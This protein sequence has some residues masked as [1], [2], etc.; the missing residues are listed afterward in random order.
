[1]P[2]IT[3]TLSVKDQIQESG[4]DRGFAARSG[5][6]VGWYICVLLQILGAP[7]AAQTA[8]RTVNYSIRHFT[9]ENGLPQN[10]VKS[11]A[12]DQDGFIWLATEMGL[13]RFDGQS[14]LT[15]NKEQSGLHSNQIIS[16]TPDLEGRKGQLYAL[17]ALLDHIKIS[18]GKAVRDSNLLESRFPA[19][20]RVKDGT[21]G[22]AYS[23]GLPDPY[24]GKHPVTHY[25]F[26]FP[27]KKGSFYLWRKGGEIDLYENW[28]K[29]KTYRTG[30]L[31]PFGIFRLGRNLYIDDRRG[32]IELLAT[33]SRSLEKPGKIKLTP[34]RSNHALPDL[35]KP[36][37]IYSH[38]LTGQ[39]FIRQGLQLY[40]LSHDAAGNI[41]TDL[42]LQYFDFQQTHVISIFFD[43]SNRRLFMGTLNNGLFILDLHAF[44]TLTVDDQNPQSNIFYSHIAYSDSTVL[45]PSFQVLGKKAS[46]QTIAYALPQL[47]RGAS[48]NVNTVLISRTGDIWYRNINVLY[49]YDGQSKQLKGKWTIGKDGFQI[50]ED[51]TGRIWIGTY[52]NGLLYIDPREKGTPVHAF[53]P[54]IKDIIF[55]LEDGADIVWVATGAGLFKISHTRKTFSLVP[56]TGNFRVKSLFLFKAGELWLNTYAHGLFLLQGNRLTRLPLDKKKILSNSHCFL[57]DKN[58]FL[59]VTT[60]HGLFRFSRREALEFTDHRDSTRLYYHRFS[61]RNGFYIDEFNGTCEPCAVSLGNGYVSLPSIHGLVFF[62]PELTPLDLPD[63]QIFIDRIEVDSREIPVNGPKLELSDVSDMHV[64]VSSP[65]LGNREN[66]QLYYS[67]SSDRKANATPIWYP[68]ENDQQSIHLNNLE[69]GTYILKIRKNTGFGPKSEQLT[70]LTIVIPYAWYET[71]PFKLIVVTLVLVAIYFYFKTRLKK[72]DRMNRILES[73]VSEKTRNLQDTLSVLKGSEQELLRQT[74]LQ[75]HLIASISHDIRSPLRS[76]EF[77]SSRLPNLIHDGNYTLAETV[78]TSVNDSSKKILQLLENMLSYVKSQVSGNS[79]AYD[80]FSARNLVDEVAVIFDEAFVAHQNK[81][82]N[83]V[84]ATVMIRSNR[85][86][87][88][89]IL[90]NLVDNANKYTPEGQV[91]VSATEQGDRITLLVS[92]TGPGLPDGVQ[93][94]FNQGDETYLESLDRGSAVNGIGLVIVREL[95]ELINLSIAAASVPGAAFSIEFWKE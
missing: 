70:S 79:V 45:T 50:Y 6:W 68:I 93:N 42:L 12:Q 81:F 8:T 56:K 86:L 94:W 19:M 25:L 24:A 60:N 2:T 59:W 37:E 14:F 54:K 76:I 4:M 53:T 35:A 87:L 92:D 20:P 77:A 47:V 66:Q 21:S 28:K 83:R 64:Y 5:K 75:M 48:P 61:K 9:D 88:K 15:Y 74:R 80:T 46:G 11:I 30:V 22:W 73:R 51:G 39:S 57:S 38:D 71:W 43:E 3:S 40:L 65:Y 90:H 58:G 52:Q 85:Q 31:S 1:M 18:G 36:Y 89:I 16:F 62:Q 23:F 34:R 67:V 32:H 69:S 17:N 82:M 33:G 95:A 13:A 55:I 10:S 29:Q 49:R 44:E 84:P 27:E 63:S 72:A 91:T 26:V 41:Q 78:G 7:G